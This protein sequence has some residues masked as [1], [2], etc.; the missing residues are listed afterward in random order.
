M[1]VEEEKQQAELRRAEREN[2]RIRKIPKMLKDDSKIHLDTLFDD[3]YNH[4]KNFA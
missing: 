1:K 3:L 4:V 2:E